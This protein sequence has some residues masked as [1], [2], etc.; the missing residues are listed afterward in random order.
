[1]A[2]MISI[3][4]LG[5]SLRLGTAIRSHAVPVPRWLA[6]PPWTRAGLAH[7]IPCCHAETAATMPRCLCT[8]AGTLIQA[9]HHER[10]TPKQQQAR[11]A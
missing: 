3:L 10:A 5:L 8:E 4:Q 6:S 2:C 7:V 1:M 11:T 9:C